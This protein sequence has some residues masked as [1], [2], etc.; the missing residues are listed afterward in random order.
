VDTFFTDTKGKFLITG[1]LNTDR[2]YT[3][4]VESDR[5]SFDTTVVNFRII[6][7]LVYVPVFLRPL[8]SDAPPLPKEVLDLADYDA[9]VPAE[10]R[11]AYE[12]AMKNVSEGKADSAIS[13]FKRAVSLY[14]EYLRALNDLGVLYLKLNRL[15]EAA[16]T[17]NQAIK[18]NK[19]FPYPRLNLGLVLNR[20]GKHKEAA[21][22]LGQLQ[23]S[24]PNLTSAR[25]PL[26]DA[27][28]EIGKL[29][30]AKE[31]LRVALE[32][33]QLEP[34][35]QAD[36]R[37]RLGSVLNREEHFA[38]AA[39]ELERAVALAP[40]AAMAHLQ[41]GGAHLQ[42]KRLAEAERALLRAYELGGS[43]VGGAQLLLGQLYF[44]QQRYEPSLRAFEQYLKDLPA[45][46]N[47]AQVRKA[48]E[49]VKAA[50]RGKQ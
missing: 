12:Q 38:E 21:E 35:T 36:A 9:K 48:I 7:A 50:L 40:N 27:L 49:Q 17:F 45:A 23:K 29:A 6:R 42:L 15:E 34:A 46:P 44:I 16:E 24:H 13:D 10:A 28:M 25:L 19:R 33:A 11:A 8:K 4:R 2:E 14:P 22:V 3:I 47:A 32:S 41:L 5:R 30:E 31:H 26:A 37:Y 43:T 1:A 18:L 20:Q 39:V